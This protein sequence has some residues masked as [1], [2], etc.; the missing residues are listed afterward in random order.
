MLTIVSN[1]EQAA[2]KIEGSWDE[3]MLD[4]FAA[5]KAVLTELALRFNEP[6][7]ETMFRFGIT[8]CEIA[9]FKGNEEIL[10]EYGLKLNK[11]GNSLDG[12]R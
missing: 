8:L 6:E 3:T 7:K 1:Q 12:Y 2:A 9:G 4:L 11:R 10:K 5:N